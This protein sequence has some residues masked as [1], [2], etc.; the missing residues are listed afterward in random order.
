MNFWEFLIANGTDTLFLTLFLAF[1][2]TLFVCSIIYKCITRICRCINI[3]K[4]GWPPSHCD[5]DGD[6]IEED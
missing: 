6:H 5:A 3:S 1:L 2:F 4:S